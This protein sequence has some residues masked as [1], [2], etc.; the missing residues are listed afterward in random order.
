MFPISEM[1]LVEILAIVFCF[2]II[3]L[4]GVIVANGFRFKT[5][6]SSDN[7]YELYD[8]PLATDSLKGFLFIF[9]AL[10]LVML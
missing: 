9:G 3:S 2:G 8:P 7:N 10:L 4:S 6:Y 5:N 1:S